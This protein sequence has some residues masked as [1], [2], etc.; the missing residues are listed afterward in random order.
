[1]RALAL[2]LL[3]AAV[4]APAATGTADA[5]FKGKISRIG[6]DLRAQ[7]VGTSWRKG[8]PVALRALRRLTLRHWKFNGMPRTG[9]L[10][11]HED[12][13]RDLVRVFRTLFE[14][15]YPIRRMQPIDR[16]GGNDFRSIEADNTSAFNCRTATGT[17]SW[18]NHAYGKAIDLNPIENPYVEGGR[19]Y[20]DKSWRYVDRSRRLK[21]MVH[22][23][24]V[25]VQAFASIGWG[26]GGT[27]SGSVKD[28]QHFSWNGR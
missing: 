4:V 15:G 17:G 13:A 14:A 26:W 11:V 16:Y 12:V 24:D 7:M 2:L 25:V 20:H 10:I 19:V 18:S 3:L 1:M 6:P 9:H 21:G 27:W 5:A 8:C 22:S 23:G 28:Y